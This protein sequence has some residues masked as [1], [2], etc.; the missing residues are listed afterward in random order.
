MTEGKPA[1]IEPAWLLFV[2]RL[3][4]TPAYLRVKVGRRLARI[5]AVALKSTVYVLPRSAGTLEDFEWLRKE[6]EGDGGEASVL[7]ARFVQGLEDRDVEALFRA[8]RDAD[9]R[10]LCGEI[11]A[12]RKKSKTKK[13]AR[14]PKPEQLA[15]VDRL[16]RRLRDIIALDFFQAPERARATAAL[17]SLR[18]SRS[19][20]K[21]GARRKAPDVRG[22]IWVTRRGVHV[23]RI[24]TAWL[25]RRFVEEGAVLKFVSPKGYVPSNG[26]LRFDMFEAEYGHE[27]GR[28]TFETVIDRFGLDVPGLS[29][30]AEIVHDL[31]I[32]DARYRRPETEGVAAL[33]NGICLSETDD[34][35]RI[36]RGSAALDALLAEFRRKRGTKEETR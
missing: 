5:G 23:D 2:H 3:P 33:I 10:E 19:D 30:I 24:A 28:C 9:Y 25:I 17:Q 31:D 18:E 27:G 4:P 29:A 1:D 35:A 36:A 34:E 6:V 8:A 21:P 14:E 26:E 12:L 15:E 32:K 20:A 22:K 7:E 13:K 11:E 16:D